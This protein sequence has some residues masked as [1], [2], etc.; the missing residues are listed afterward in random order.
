VVGFGGGSATGAGAFGAVGAATATRGAAP[1]S[2]LPADPM[3]SAREIPGN[4]AADGT[5]QGFTPSGARIGRNEA[6]WCG[7]GQKYKKCHGA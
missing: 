7:S 5:R 2:G 4:T 6:C 1:I 3:K